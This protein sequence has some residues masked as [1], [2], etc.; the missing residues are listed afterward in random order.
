VFYCSETFQFV[1][2]LS[3]GFALL[4]HDK[5]LIFCNI[6]C[7][8]LTGDMWTLYFHCVGAPKGQEKI[9]L[10]MDRA[11]ISFYTLFRLKSRFGYTAR[12]YI[13]YK[14]RCGRTVAT[15]QVLDFEDQAATMIE[16]NKREKEIRL[17]MTTE[18][19]RELQ[20][21]ITPLKRP[22]DRANTN[23]PCRDDTINLYK[24]WLK[25]MYEVDENTGNICCYTHLN[26]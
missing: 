11:D 8:R 2:E 20:V 21:A 16:N 7:V 4:Y 23:V 10:Q 22:R 13:Y 24:A 14:Q 17:L 19:P 26:K 9:E 3:L 15:L 5:L 12:D 6:Y 18:Q 1:N 25:D